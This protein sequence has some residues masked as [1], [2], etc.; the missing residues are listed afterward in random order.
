M[1]LRFVIAVVASAASPLTAQRLELASAVSIVAPFSISSTDAP[2][3]FS[4]GLAA[5]LRVGMPHQR[6]WFLFGDVGAFTLQRPTYGGPRSRWK[7]TLFASASLGRRM[8]DAFY[9]STGVGTYFAKSDNAGVP[10][11]FDFGFHGALG[12]TQGKVF[13]EAKY[14][15]VVDGSLGARV[16]LSVGRRF[17]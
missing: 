5:S 10:P 17:H 9:A 8:G 12:V 4:G 3:P 2:A 1:H 16:V 11:E 13:A 15:H 7:N 6:T 14:L